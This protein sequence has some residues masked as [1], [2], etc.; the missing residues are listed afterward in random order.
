VQDTLLSRRAGNTAD[1]KDYIAA[2]ICCLNSLFSVAAVCYI[3][4]KS[5]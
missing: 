4:Y 2:F 5:L 3:E 1:A